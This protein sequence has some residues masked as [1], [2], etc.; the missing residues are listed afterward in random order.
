MISIGCSAI[1]VSPKRTT[2]RA[3]RSSDTT[4]KVS[5]DCRAS[6]DK[7]GVQGFDETWCGHLGCMVVGL[8]QSW[9]YGLTITELEIGYYRLRAPVKMS[10][11]VLLPWS[12]GFL[13]SR[14]PATG[15][16]VPQHVVSSR[17]ARRR[18]VPAAPSELSCPS[19]RCYPEGLP[20]AFTASA[21]DG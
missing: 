11:G 4:G 9:L 14:N 18:G 5:Y 1:D 15:R 3:A 10:A 16:F 8:C 7:T 21:S 17:L 20:I 12:T 13:A 6:A 2:S 19:L